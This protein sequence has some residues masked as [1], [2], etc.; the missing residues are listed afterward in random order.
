MVLSTWQRAERVSDMCTDTYHTERGVFRP[1]DSTEQSG[2]RQEWPV[3]L[4]CSDRD[5]GYGADD[6]FRAQPLPEQPRPVARQRVCAPHVVTKR[7]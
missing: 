5:F 3:F 7:V 2:S 1:C 4:L 6:V